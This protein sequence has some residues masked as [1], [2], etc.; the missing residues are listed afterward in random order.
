MTYA[1]SLSLQTNDLIKSMDENSNTKLYNK[2]IDNLK[3]VASVFQAV[4][5]DVIPEWKQAPGNQPVETIREFSVALS[6]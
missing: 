1:Y 5:T 6:K 4:S 2:A 3:T